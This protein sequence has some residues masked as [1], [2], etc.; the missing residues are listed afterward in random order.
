MITLEL[1]KALL[2]DA[3]LKAT[4]QRMVILS[5]V[6]KSK[7]HPSAEKVHEQ[8]RVNNPSMSLA[9]VYSTLDTFVEKGLIQK[10]LVK[11]GVKRYD[12]HLGIHHHIHS[13]NTNEIFDFVD[14]ELNDL[15]LEF[16]KT[17]NIGNLDIRKFSLHV[18][19]EKIDVKKHIEIH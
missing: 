6:H 10:V 9:T 5:A 15:I 14:E 7:N 3:G 16:L 12:G 2:A 18:Q 8:V 13:T 11:D 4:Q 17:K 1:T 19:G